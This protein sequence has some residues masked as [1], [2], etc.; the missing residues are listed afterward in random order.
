[1]KR[2]WRFDP[3]T[4]RRYYEIRDEYPTFLGLNRD[5]WIKLAIMSVLC[6]L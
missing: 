5:Q 3:I 2:K 6:A 1:M 4:G